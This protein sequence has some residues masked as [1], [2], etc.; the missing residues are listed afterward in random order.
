LRCEELNGAGNKNSTLCLNLSEY[1]QPIGQS[2]KSTQSPSRLNAVCKSLGQRSIAFDFDWSGQH[3]CSK[4][5][6][7]SGNPSDVN[8]WARSMFPWDS[9]AQITQK[10]A[11]FEPIDQIH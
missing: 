8:P 5:C 1:G 3:K 4:H 7:L 11:N 2:F 6:M 9:N 10:N